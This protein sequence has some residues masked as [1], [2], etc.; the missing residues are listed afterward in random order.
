MFGLGDRTGAP[1]RLGSWSRRAEMKRWLPFGPVEDGGSQ[2]RGLSIPRVAFLWGF[3][4]ASPVLAFILYGTGESDSLRLITGI[5]YVQD[6][7]WRW[8]LRTQ[9]PVLPH[10]VYGPWVALSTSTRLMVVVPI[11]SSMALS[12]MTAY[13]VA[14]LTNRLAWGIGAAALLVS[15]R[16]FLDQARELPLYPI[17]TIAGTLGLW[18][19]IRTVRGDDARTS[20][21]FLGGLL[22]ALAV[23]AHGAGLYF[24]PLSFM[25]IVFV[26]DRAA[27]RRYLLGMAFVTICLVPWAISHLWIGGLHR[28]MTPRDT[29]IVSKGYVKNI[30]LF[31]GHRIESPFASAHRLPGLLATAV[32]WPM[33]LAV[34]LAAVGFTALSKRAQAFAVLALLGLASPIIV[35]KTGLFPRYFYPPLP[36]LMI[37]AGLGMARIHEAL[38]SADRE[39]IVSIYRRGLMA[40]MAA[41]LAV[42]VLPYMR[43]TRRRYYLPVRQAIP[44]MAALI[45]DGKAVIGARSF[46]L[47]YASSR[48]R[49]FHADLLSESEYV[50]YLT[51][52]LPRLRQVLAKYDIGWAILRQPVSRWEIGYNASWLMPAYGTSPI[53][54]F[55]LAKETMSCLVY[56]RRGY[57]LY[58]LQP[59][60]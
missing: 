1:G 32:K 59:C 56:H 50:A 49:V 47:M 46:N 44:G 11:V 6:V 35:F 38:R 52:D 31:R 20:R 10:L 2:R 23:M 18:I 19:I 60:E 12:G 15:S 48:I 22:I 41:L 54:P 36:G 25:S 43:E 42:A 45:D 33:W 57:L 28:F 51:W 30:N 21:A 29:W 53:H 40:L 14:R 26:K 5:K 27:F 9:D 13:L 55:E 3:V 24:L 17:F 37:L 7:D 39:R 34:P 8:L 4:I 58:K 16:I